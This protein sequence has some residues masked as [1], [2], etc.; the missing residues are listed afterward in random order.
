MI[1]NQLRAIIKGEIVEEDSK[2]EEYSRDASIFEVRPQLVIK[3][4]DAEDIKSLVRFVADNKSAIPDLSLTARAGGS[5]MSGGPL[6]ESIILDTTAHMNRIVNVEGDPPHA[7]VEPGVFYRDFE[8]ETLKKGLLLPSYPASRELCAIGGMVANNS[9]GEK[10]LRYGKTEDYVEELNVVL[11]DG[12]EYVFRALTLDELEQKKRQS[13]FEGDIYRKMHELLET[14]YELIQKARPDVSKN[15]AGYAL[16]SVYRSD[17]YSDRFKFDLTKLFVGSQ[18]TLGVISKIK[19]RLIKPAKYSRLLVIFLK[20]LDKVGDLVI[21]LNRYNPESVES[22]DD[23]TIKLVFK[24]LPDLVKKIGISVLSRF[25]PDL[26]AIVAGGGIP[27]LVV[28]AEFTGDDEENIKRKTKS[29]KQEIESRFHVKT[30]IAENP[31]DIQK[32]WTIRRESFNLLRKH[33]KGKKTAPF[34]DDVIVRPE[35]L[36]EFL[37]E[38]NKILGE[39]KDYMV[40]TIAGHPGDGNFHIIPLMDLSDERS[41]RIIPELSEKVYDLVLKYNGSITA[42]HNDGLIRTPYLEKMYGPEICDLFKEVKKIFDPQ[43]IFNPRKKVD[44]SSRGGDIKYA[45]EHVKI[46]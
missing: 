42:E 46:Y 20:D 35:H 10:S 7:V 24:I 26:W 4:K 6:N 41:R 3:P 12:N 22:Y 33:V 45:I 31:A 1:S 28:L 30:R 5:D 43:N 8:K 2:L 18:G 23:N 25:I 16:W 44:L 40:Y 37:P 13:N 39:Y 17:Q 21:D 19:F 27:R 29:A 34:I 14:N 38:L 36:P 32:Y 11:S 15:S 9:G